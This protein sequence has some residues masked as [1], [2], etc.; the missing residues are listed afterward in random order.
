MRKIKVAVICGGISNEREVSLN[1]GNNVTATLSK[2]KYKISKIEITSDGK[3]L[4]DTTSDKEYGT[5]KA[6]ELNVL[7]GNVNKKSDLLKFDVAFIALHGYFGEDGKIQAILD[8]VGIPYTGSGVLASALGMDKI[9]SMEIAKMAGVLIPD[10]IAINKRV[11]L[12]IKKSKSEIKR[13]IGYPCVVK[14]NESGSSVGV[15]I[16]HDETGLILALKTA[17]RED[18][19]AIVQKFV[20]GREL[21]CGVL[22]N[23]GGKHIALPPVEIITTRKFFD[24]E[25]KYSPETREICPANISKR[26]SQDVKK[27]SKKVHDSLGCDGLTR[28]DFIL[29]PRGKLYF[30]EINTIPGLTENSLCPKEARAMGIGFGEFLDRQIELALEKE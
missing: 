24:Y 5:R 12:N 2:S 14:P 9:K 22:G 4:L 17:L 27:L 19:N 13:K 7:N 30:L 28:S 16:V 26:L 20:K 18:T 3:W 25:A 8:T 23:N 21:T 15:S 6:R 11:K 10:F 1:S 29:S